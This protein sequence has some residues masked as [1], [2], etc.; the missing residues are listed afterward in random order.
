MSIIIVN[1]QYAMSRRASPLATREKQIFPLWLTHWGWTINWKVIKYCFSKC[2]ELSN[3]A[4]AS[5]HNEDV[6]I[7]KLAHCLCAAGHARS[8]TAARR[9]VLSQETGGVFPLHVLSVT[10]LS[11]R[12]RMWRASSR[13][14]W[15]NGI[16][17]T[18]ARMMKIPPPFDN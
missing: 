16:E 8:S 18:L 10:V 4:P 7:F 14:V 3:I 11:T 15:E 5:A 13:W 12:D 2:A 9:T 17:W 6:K 1:Q